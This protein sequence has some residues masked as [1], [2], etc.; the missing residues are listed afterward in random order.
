MSIVLEGRQ[1]KSVVVE[2]G[3]V[4]IVKKG[5]V[6]A[7]PRE[8]TIPIRHISSVEI[9][10]PGMAVGFIQFSLAGGRA[11]DSS[12]TL[13]GG[14]Y[15]AVQDEN[16]VVFQGQ[17]QYRTALKIKEYVETFEEP[18]TARS[19]EPVSTADEIRKLKT[20]LDEGILTDE[21]FE[22]QKRKLLGM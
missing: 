4:K 12:F 3:T 6:F 5:G 18:Q 14:A 15:G 16:S 2:G 1:G 22:A 7:A 8:K 20:L 19:A 9:K 10:K 21:E 11:R 17:E 13:T